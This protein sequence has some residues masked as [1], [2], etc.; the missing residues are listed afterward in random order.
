MPLAGVGSWKE[1]LSQDGGVKCL[2][3]LLAYV[4]F[5]PELSTPWAMEV[6]DYIRPPYPG[7]PALFFHNHCFW[8]P[9]GSIQAGAPDLPW[10]LGSALDLASALRESQQ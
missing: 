6:S 10:L 1:A 7:P 2:V 3:G 9:A 4:P 8:V 5:C